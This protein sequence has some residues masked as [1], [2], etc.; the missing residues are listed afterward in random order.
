ME[1]MASFLRPKGMDG[2]LWGRYTSVVVGCV[3]VR[4][5]TECSIPS[6]VLDV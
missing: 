4:E 6:I 2:R 5:R 1:F 3:Y